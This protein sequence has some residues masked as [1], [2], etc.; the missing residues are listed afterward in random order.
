MNQ[1]ENKI[2]EISRLEDGDMERI[3]SIEYDVYVGGVVHFKNVIDIPEKII[4]YIDENA[5]VPSCGLEIVDKED[6]TKFCRDF[7]GNISAYETL[8]S[9]PMRLGGFG[10]PGPVEKYTPEDI[11]A[12]FESCEKANYFC[13]VRYMDLY[14]LIVNTIWWKDR[15]HVLKYLPGASLGVHNDNDTN[16][17]V[18]DGQRYYSQ[19]DVAMHQVVNS[20]IYFNDDYEGGE[21]RFPYLDVTLKPSRGDI[22]FFPANYVGSHAV[23]PVKSG[24]RYTYLSQFCQGGHQHQIVEA[25]ESV[26]WLPPVFLPFLY[27]DHKKFFESGFSHFDESKDLELGLHGNSLVAQNRSVEGPATGTRLAYD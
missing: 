16:F 3:D 2:Q 1:T 8:L 11:V 25:Q 12:F 5:Y 10:M 9:L 17:R 23:A 27:Q 20:L 4:S 14:P 15:G 18:I 7:E 22:V 6:G 13:L 26:E 24:Y 21:F 19:R